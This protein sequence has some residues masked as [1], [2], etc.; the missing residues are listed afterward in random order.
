MKS[1][2]RNE[3][4][5]IVGYFVGLLYNLLFIYLFHPQSHIELVSIFKP[6]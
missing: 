5:L 4:L 1:K 2:T 3:T 6:W